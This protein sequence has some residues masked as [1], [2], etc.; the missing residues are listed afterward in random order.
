MLCVLSFFS[1]IMYGQEKLI[2]F[3]LRENCNQDHFKRVVQT[4]AV[5]K[6]KVLNA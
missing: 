4:V 2:K 3:T 5:A 1:M 6:K